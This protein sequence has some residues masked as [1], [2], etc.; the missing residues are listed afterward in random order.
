MNDKSAMA[1]LMLCPDT[2]SSPELTFYK[3]S[4]SEMIWENGEW[5]DSDMY[6]VSNLIFILETCSKTQ[7]TDYTVSDLG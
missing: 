5:I 7:M 3:V 1:N 2:K 4:R 6:D